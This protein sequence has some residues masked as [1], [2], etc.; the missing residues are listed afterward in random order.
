MRTTLP[1][2]LQT[3]TY[4]R[5]ANR[6][7]LA[8]GAVHSYHIDPDSAMQVRAVAG[9]L[10]ITLEGDPEDHV[11]EA[12]KT[13]TLTSHG[14]LVAEGLCESNTLEYYEIVPAVITRWA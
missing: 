1:S 9:A 13:M 14:L 6:V 2:T 10:W 7:E 12:G 5:T 4:D 8:K 11:L 3:D